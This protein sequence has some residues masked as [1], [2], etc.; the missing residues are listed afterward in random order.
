MRSLPVARAAGGVSQHPP[1]VLQR[2][3]LSLGPIAIRLMASVMEGR[4]FY[5]RRLVRYNARPGVEMSTMI[6]RLLT[7]VASAVM[8]LAIAV[9]LAVLVSA[10]QASTLR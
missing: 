8:A 3:R 6:R 5:G 7:V 4:P 2:A 9:W 10:Q 1:G